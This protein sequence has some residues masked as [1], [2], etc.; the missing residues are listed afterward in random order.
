[1][2]LLLPAAYI[3]LT[4]ITRV[5]R[6]LKHVERAR[7]DQSD[8]P[9]QMRRERPSA[10][11]SF[12]QSGPVAIDSDDAPPSP[13]RQAIGPEFPLPAAADSAPRPGFHLPFFRQ[14]QSITQTLSPAPLHRNPSP[15]SWD[16][17]RASVASSRFP[18]FAPVADKSNGYARHQPEDENDT[19]VAESS[20]P[21]LHGAEAD[22]AP[23]SMEGHETPERLELDVKSPD[24]G[25]DNTFR[26][27]YR[28]TAPSREFLLL[29]CA[30]HSSQASSHPRNIARC[31]RADHHPPYMSA[32]CLPTVGYF[33]ALSIPTKS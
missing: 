18:T 4:C 33:Q 19:D 32:A 10:H 16:D 11:F 21:W 27:S 9:R 29:L 31:E 26:L 15:A 3:S 30:I 5:L 2:A 12:K 28:D 6:T 8:Y 22:S 7:R 1:M 14:L 13:G 17:G 24:E 20:S 25:D 23:T